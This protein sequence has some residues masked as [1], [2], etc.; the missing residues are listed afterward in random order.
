MDVEGIVFSRQISILLSNL[1]IRFPHH[2]VLYFFLPQALL[3]IKGDLR[4]VCG[5]P[6]ICIRVLKRV[7]KVLRSVKKEK[8]WIFYLPLRTLFRLQNHKFL[9]QPFLPIIWKNTSLYTHLCDRGRHQPAVPTTLEGDDHLNRSKKR[10]KKIFKGDS[11]G[12]IAGHC[13]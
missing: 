13:F 2:S 3:C 11:R 10:T 5:V 6:N 7:R 8:K 9:S 12:L 4:L 1:Y